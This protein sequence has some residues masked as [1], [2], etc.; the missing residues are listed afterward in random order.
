MLRSHIHAF[1]LEV[2]QHE[3]NRWAISQ[4]LP[5]P[6]FTVA[7]VDFVDAVVLAHVVPG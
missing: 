3:N 7:P 2:F 5:L 4:E 6:S 1:Q